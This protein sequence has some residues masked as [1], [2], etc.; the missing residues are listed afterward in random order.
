MAFLNSA[1]HTVV[2]DEAGF[3]VGKILK[4]PL[5]SSIWLAVAP[6]LPENKRILPTHPPLPPF[7]KK[8]KKKKKKGNRTTLSYSFQMHFETL[9]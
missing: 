8:K 9:Y 4:L 1:F 5:Q 3:A 6:W 7:K 2:Y